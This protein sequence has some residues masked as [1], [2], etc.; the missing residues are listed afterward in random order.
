MSRG[1]LEE[2]LANRHPGPTVVVTHHAPLIRSR[3]SS[4]ALRALAGAFASDVTGLMSG[5][6]VSLWIFGHTH[7]AADLEMHGTRLVSNPRGYP[8]QP[9]SAF[10]PGCVIEVVAR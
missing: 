6:R 9:V 5:D 4:P 7:R 10:D 3:P 1:W 8:H 2:R